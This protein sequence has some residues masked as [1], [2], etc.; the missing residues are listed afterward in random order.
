MRNTKNQHGGEETRKFCRLDF[1]IKYGFSKSFIPERNGIYQ[2]GYKYITLI[3]SLKFTDQP[4][5]DEFLQP[6]EIS[7]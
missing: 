7:V 4:M 5:M 3:F 1:I 6:Q 2:F